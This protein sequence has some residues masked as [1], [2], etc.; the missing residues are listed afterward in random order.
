MQLGIH[1]ERHEASK[2]T[3]CLF[4]LGSFFLVIQQ[5]GHSYTTL[6]GRS[7]LRMHDDGDQVRA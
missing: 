6:N 7:S 1:D 5:A 3:L 4:V 2:K